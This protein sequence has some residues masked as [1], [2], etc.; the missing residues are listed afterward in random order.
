MRNPSFTG[1]IETDRIFRSV[2]RIYST[3]RRRD[4]KQKKKFQQIGMRLL[5]ISTELHLN[6]EEN[7]HKYLY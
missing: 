3:K 7:I 4:S 6:S 1:E 2:Q 5:R